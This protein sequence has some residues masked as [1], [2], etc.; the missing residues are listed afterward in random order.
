MRSQAKMLLFTGTDEVKS[1]A[2]SFC[3]FG[4]LEEKVKIIVESIAYPFESISFGCMH[5]DRYMR[6]ATKK[7]KLCFHKK[8]KN[9][10]HILVISSIEQRVYVTQ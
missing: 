4:T 3:M 1:A 9:I 5:I 6:R 8:T 7:T 10:R 2:Y